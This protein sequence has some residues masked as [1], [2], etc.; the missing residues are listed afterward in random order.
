MSLDHEYAL[1]GGYNRTHL[2]RW[3]YA[4]AALISAGIVFLVLSGVDVAKVSGLNVNLPPTF[5]ALISA[6][7]VY[8]ALYAFFDRFAWKFT[9]IARHL[10]LPDL[11]GTWTCTGT[12]IEPTDANP[13]SGKVT[14][15]QSWDRFRVHL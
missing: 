3:L 7:A 1:L 14:I 9:P 6:G 11:S 10:K 5:L 12:P 4:I 2:G 13:W 15:V 8:A